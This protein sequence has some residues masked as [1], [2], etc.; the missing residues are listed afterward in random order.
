MPRQFKSTDTSIWS[1]GFGNGKDGALTVS[2]NGNTF[3]VASSPFT[4]NA[5]AY[6]L[7]GGSSGATSGAVSD[8]WGFWTSYV[9]VGDIV[10]IHQTFGSGA[11][12]WELNVVTGGLPSGGGSS[13]LTLKYPLQNNYGSGCQIIKCPQFS[14]FT[15]NSGNALYIRG[16]GSN[17]THGGIMAFF[18]TGT[19][20][21]AGT[22]TATYGGFY[23][24]TEPSGTGGYQGYSSTGYASMSVSPNGAGGGGG[25]YG[26][27]AG[28]GHG[29]GGGNGTAGGSGTPSSRQ[30]GYGGSTDGNS[31]LTL[32]SIGA[33]GGAGGH[34]RSTTGGRGG[35]GG[36]GIMIFTNKL[37]VTGGLRADGEDGQY[38]TGGTDSAGSGGGGAGGSILVKAITATLGT[39]LVG[40]GGGQGEPIGNPDG[41]GGF[42]RIHLDY[43]GSYTGTTT[44]TLDATQDVSLLPK[45]GNFIVN[46][47]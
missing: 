9:S 26:D 47:I 41:D 46:F 30:S 31:S 38:K 39:N 44:P 43:A 15:L 29:A 20:T 4:T 33:G 6:G 12:N 5:N 13:T 19:T 22:L 36:G 27:G 35:A 25:A 16:L 10:L 42:G 17:L 23:Y 8:A 7:F 1:E 37:V 3:Q 11:G 2:T 14:S 45:G 21:I 24:G 34:R 40:A 28:A 18:C 32:F